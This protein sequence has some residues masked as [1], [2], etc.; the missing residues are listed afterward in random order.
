MTLQTLRSMLIAV[1]G[2]F[3]GLAIGAGKAE[4]QAATQPVDAV[5]KK[6]GI[7][8]YPGVQVIDFTGPF[9]VLCH[10][11]SKG[12]RLFDVVTVGLSDEMIRTGP[13]DHGLKITPEFSI[14]SAPELDILVIPGGEIGEVDNN[15]KAMAWIADV[16]K[17]A[18]CVMSVCN[19][20]FILAKGGH[21]KNQQATTFYWFIDELKEAEPT[22]TPVHD[23]RFTDNGK[24]ITTAG[25]S[26]GIDG[27]LHLIE[28]YSSRYD[29]EQAALGLEYDWQPERNWARANLADWHLVKMLGSAGFNFP[30]GSLAQW[31][32]VQNNGTKDEWTKA[33]K[34]QTNL[35]RSEVIQ[36][37]E[38]K[39]AAVWT[40][41]SST[42]AESN[43][44]F[45]DDKDRP[46]TA[47]L[48]LTP[49]D[50]GNWMA[51][52]HVARTKA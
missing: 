39:M 51:E 33:W 1:I 20:A 35:E 38:S 14:D 49:S 25:L 8:I 34:F 50:G 48:E 5:P 7:L 36:A 9:E 42:D 10:G 47:R 3:I 28:R 16:V 29:A 46:W 43:W 17:E 30:K 13:G 31:T 19:G 40:K 23:Q 26:S 18:E 24:I 52:I 45:K 21:L 2:C 11:S 4:P 6:V 41:A 12:K 15:E 22:C 32:V 37:F 44:T 27:A